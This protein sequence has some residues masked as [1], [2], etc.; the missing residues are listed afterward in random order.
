MQFTLDSA[1]ILTLA[2]GT[3]L[4]ILVGLVTQKVTSSNLK[5]LLLAALSALTG[6]GSELL[7][8]VQSGAGYDFGT[9]LVSAFGVFLVAV[10]MHYGLYKNT[11]VTDAVQAVGSGRHAA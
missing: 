10:G 8:A 11:G 6:F 1:Q 7:A 4:P 5:A 2:V 3:V 9:G